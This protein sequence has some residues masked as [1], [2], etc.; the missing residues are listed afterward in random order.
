M[1]CFKS[2]LSHCYSSYS[3]GLA[4]EGQEKASREAWRFLVVRGEDMK[5]LFGVSVLGSLAGEISRLLPV[6]LQQGVEAEV[7]PQLLLAPQGQ[8]PNGTFG[9]EP[10]DIE[11]SIVWRD[12]R[13]VSLAVSTNCE[14]L[15]CE[16][17]MV[18][19]GFG[20]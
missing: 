4:L 11:V 9:A 6:L 18:L 14:V 5:D 16:H 2:S 8:H 3:S 17:L 15:T 1:A 13:Y 20:V 12:L 7:V 19:T 10:M